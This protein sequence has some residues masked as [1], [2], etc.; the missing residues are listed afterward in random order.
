MYEHPTFCRGGCG[1]FSKIPLFPK[2]ALQC[3]RCFVPTHSSVCDV[4][5]RG[6]ALLT[7]IHAILL[8]VIVTNTEDWLEMSGAMKIIMGMTSVQQVRHILLTEY[9]VGEIVCKDDIHQVIEQE[10]NALLQE[11]QSKLTKKIKLA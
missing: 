5:D 1:K 9:A 8:T 6:F 4:S 11:Y 3:K 7:H 2:Y 10:K